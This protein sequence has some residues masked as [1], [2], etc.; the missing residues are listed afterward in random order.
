M[1]GVSFEAFI[2]G[3]GDSILQDGRYEIPGS[4]I[5]IFENHTQRIKTTI[6]TPRKR[7]ILYISEF[8]LYSPSNKFTDGGMQVRHGFY[9]NELVPYTTFPNVQL[10][11]DFLDFVHDI[12][13]IQGRVALELIV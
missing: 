13:E 3:R 1:G 2:I 11:K 5:Q 7:G 6:N 8:N 9:G 12:V 4:G 10:K